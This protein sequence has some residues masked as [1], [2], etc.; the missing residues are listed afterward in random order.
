MSFV[1][2]VIDAISYSG[3]VSATWSPYARMG[4][5]IEHRE[6]R[7]RSWWSPHLQRSREF[8]VSYARPCR[9]VAVF[10]AGRLLDIDL[11]HLLSITE[12]VHLFDLDPGA[13][14]VW[15][16]AVPAKDRSR[17]F[18]RC[19]DVV[20][21]LRVW[22]HPLRRAPHRAACVEALQSLVPP[23]PHWLEER[24]DG[25]ISL[26]L[27][28]QIPLYWRDRVVALCER[29]G[30]RVPKSELELSMARLQV[31]HLDAV[32]QGAAEWSIILTD[33]E[34]YYYR[35][36]QQRWS[37]ES[38]LFGEASGSWHS[39]TKRCSAPSFDTWWW[40]LAPQ[41]VEREEYGEIHKVEALFMI[42]EVP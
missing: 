16:E 14:Q 15:R 3:S 22:E 35:D 29:R 17:V 6:G 26:N 36:G 42:N 7:C 25:I 21:C 32:T 8:I 41:F 23:P 13:I 33:T 40:H 38:A 18:F 4:L 39:L 11:L 19:E 37:A 5:G 1:R 24:Y 27:L 28:G 34:Y 31:A 10:G 2:T 12:E 30:L 9:K 20:S